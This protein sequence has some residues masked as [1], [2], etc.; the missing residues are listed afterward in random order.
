MLTHSTPNRIPLAAAAEVAARLPG[1]RWEGAGYRTR[2]YC[3]GSGDKPTS[4]S[5][6]FSDPPKPGEQSL[7]V[8][9]F[10]CNPGTPAERDAIRHALQKA[11]GLQLCSC[12]ACWEARRAGRPPDGATT[13]PEDPGQPAP[14]T[15]QP[16]PR[17]RAKSDTAAYAAELWAAAQPSTSGPAEQHPVGRWLAARTPPI[18]WPAGRP[19]PETVRW[20]AR[21]HRIFPRRQ[22]DSPAVGALVMA[23]RPLSNPVG[24]TRKVHLVAIDAEG[25]KA[26]HWQADKRGD[27]HTYGQDAAAYGLLWKQRPTGKH[28]CDLHVVEGLADGLAL[29]T[30]LPEDQIVAVC[31]GLRYSEIDPGWFASVTLWP[32]GDEKALETARRQ[33]Q[34]WA[35][36]GYTVPIKLLPKGE[37]PASMNW[38]TP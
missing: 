38:R 33:A 27:K 25:S 24:P 22:P 28:A 11:T 17:R 7:R 32:D 13:R 12:R 37:D 36:R 20:L 29:L 16:A 1:T 31:A 30:A 34:Q 10:K 21:R 4:A 35:N 14:A 3:H 6:V 9:C 23:L 2:G 8:H 26:H 15:T 19:L 5:L 18:R